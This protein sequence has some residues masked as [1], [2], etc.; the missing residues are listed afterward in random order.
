[1]LG[2]PGFAYFLQTLLPLY[3]F[4]HRVAKENGS[5]FGPAQKDH[6]CIM[7]LKTKRLGFGQISPSQ[8]TGPFDEIYL[9]GKCFPSICLFVYLLVFNHG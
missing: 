3:K 2:H 4:C 5:I 1:M 9:A 8:F 6:M 7:T